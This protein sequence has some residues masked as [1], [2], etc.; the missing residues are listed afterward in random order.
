MPQIPY[1]LVP[2]KVGDKITAP[3]KEYLGIKDGMPICYIDPN[4]YNPTISD[5][6]MTRFAWFKFP[7]STKQ[8]FVDAMDSYNTNSQNHRARKKLINLKEVGQFLGDNKIEAEWRSGN[9]VPIVET[10]L[11]LSIFK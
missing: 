2:F 1:I 11:P 6:D 9:K 4:E 10:E 5:G 8:Y 7:L 3:G